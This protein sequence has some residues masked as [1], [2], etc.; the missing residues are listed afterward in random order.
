MINIILM[1]NGAISLV[2]NIVL[3]LDFNE[4]FNMTLKQL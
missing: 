2:I 4:Y 3:W 1:E